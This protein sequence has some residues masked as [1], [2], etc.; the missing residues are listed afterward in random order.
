MELISCV[1]LD[2]M[3]INLNNID[4]GHANKDPVVLKETQILERLI[5]RC[6]KYKSNLTHAINSKSGAEFNILENIFS[7]DYLQPWD[8]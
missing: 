6:Q 8:D 4:C 3:F 2:N 5:R 7:I 1:K